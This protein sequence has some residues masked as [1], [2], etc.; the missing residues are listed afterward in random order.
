MER[1]VIGSP[2]S[3]WLETNVNEAVAH[4]DECRGSGDH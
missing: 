3:A 4:Q 1:C 2:L